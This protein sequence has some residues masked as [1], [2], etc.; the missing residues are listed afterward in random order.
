MRKFLG[1]YGFVAVLMIGIVMGRLSAG[2]NLGVIPGYIANIQTKTSGSTING[3]LGGP[4]CGT[5][6]SVT[7]SSAGTVNLPSTAVIGCQVTIIQGGTAKVS[8]VAVSPA[9]LNANPH[10]FT[11]TFGQ[12]SHIAV[13][14]VSNAGGNA[15]VYDLIGDG[16]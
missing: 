5:A 14:V 4:D 9:V 2:P 11:G 15:A 7:V 3:A 12:T 16:S 6:W 10:G 1:R 13:E 8:P